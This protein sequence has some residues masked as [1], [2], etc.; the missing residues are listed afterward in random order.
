MG[1]RPWGDVVFHS[2]VTNITEIVADGLRY[3]N[4]I[5]T[6]WDHSKI[7]VATSTGGELLVYDR[8]SNNKLHLSENVF[9]GLC[10]DNVSVDET[11]EIYCP[12]MYIYVY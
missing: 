1:R 7:Y 8:K 4:G 10:L 12:G 11:G 5:A 6:N 2:P 3:P 9:L